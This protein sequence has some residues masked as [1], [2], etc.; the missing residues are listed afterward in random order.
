MDASL[1]GSGGNVFDDDFSL[2]PIFSNL[3]ASP[4]TPREGAVCG[5][6]VGVKRVRSIA[7]E[8]H[9]ADHVVP[10]S[11]KVR[12]TLTD[13]DYITPPRAPVHAA[14]Q[15]ASVDM[16]IPPLVLDEESVVPQGRCSPTSIERD[17]VDEFISDDMLCYETYSSPQSLPTPRQFSPTNS[18]CSLPTTPM[19]EMFYS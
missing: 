14:E 12:R 18:P 2:S 3:V 16:D 15:N 8:L 7:K 6:L 1:H 5:S 10:E 17:F 19:W 13:E 9:E 4:K 11:S